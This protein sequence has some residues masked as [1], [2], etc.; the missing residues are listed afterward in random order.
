MPA[1]GDDLL[2]TL[3]DSRLL[4]SAQLAE[5]VKSLLPQHAVADTL[6]NELV[7]RGWVTSYQMTQ[8]EAGQGAGLV[9]GSYGLLELLG[10]GGMGQ[11]FK[12]RHV[13]M[14]RLVAL[15]VI[16]PELLADDHAVRRFRREI[17][18][19]AQLAHPNVAIA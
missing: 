6:G 18:I 12:A 13:L 3:R 5:L 8:L 15:K 11:V 10:Q 16:R 17:Q 9:R 14:N 7:R 2:N 19:A 1:P 4:D